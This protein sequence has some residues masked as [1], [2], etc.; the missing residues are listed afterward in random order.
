MNRPHY[1]ND[2]SG[3]APKLRVFLNLDNLVDL[4]SSSIWKNP[5]REELL[6]HLA[7]DGFEG[8]QLTQDGPPPLGSLPHCGLGRIN[9]PGEALPLAEKHAK[10]GD[11]CLT[12]HAGWGIEDDDEVFRLV[13]AILSASQKAR[14]P[15]FI[16]THRATITQDMWRTVQ[17]AKRF[18]EVLFNGDFSHYYCGQEMVYGGLEKKIEF[19]QPIFD[20]IGFMHGRIAS[21]GHMQVP[22]DATESRPAAAVGLVDYYA[23]FRTIW[24]R[25]M[26]GF[27][28]N[29]G[30]GDVLLFTPEL[31][32]GTHYYARL[33]P[34]PDGKM[35]EESDRYAQAI[36]YAK[37]VR[38]LFQE[39]SALA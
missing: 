28:E 17:I 15:I 38:E 9:E 30:P 31:L 33:F 5:P 13:E 34:C 26:R 12:V 29:A 22:I 37:V 27:R 23:D 36:L 20:R 39:A 6:K 7:T 14:L 35:T 8:V 11:L 19:M 10:R 24:A 16:E 3:D 25:A 32:S 21:P 1:L 2:G 4:P 18:P